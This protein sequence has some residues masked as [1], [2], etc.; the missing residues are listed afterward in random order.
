MSARLVSP[1]ERSHVR[2][3]E[4]RPQ[5][6][7]GAQHAYACLMTT[8]QTFPL[9]TLE[10]LLGSV[11]VVALPMR[12]KFRGVTVRETALFQG[13]S[14]WGEF[15]PFPEYQDAEASQW[16]R[17]GLEAAWLGFPEPLRTSIPVN[18]TVPA[19]PAARV[20][21]VLAGYDARSRP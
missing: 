16:L 18:A 17:A 14:G 10:D 4:V 5:S 8:P 21:N 20:P 7:V 12:V 6:S 15:G 11:R 13:P 19:V 3:P 9:P 1:A 2:T